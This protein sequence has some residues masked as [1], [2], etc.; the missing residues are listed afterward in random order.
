M[1]ALAQSP[2]Q[3]LRLHKDNPV[4][5]RL[6]GPEALAEAAAQDKPIFLSMGYAGC[7]WCHVMNREC[8]SD[9][10]IAEIINENF[11]PILADREDRPDLDLIYQAAAQLMGA[12]GG[13]PLNIFLTPRGLP[14]FVTGFMP[15][16]PRQGQEAFPDMLRNIVT[17][18]K[19]RQDQVVHNSGV[20]LQKLDTLFNRDMRAAP[21]T[22]AL[23]AAAL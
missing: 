4:A 13:W 2:S 7:H 21:E 6:W 9:A 8:F 5:W 20:I 14:F 3:Y 15:P 23:D 10:A 11:I 19:E 16:T 18:Y 12:Q 1:N 22:I 17:Q